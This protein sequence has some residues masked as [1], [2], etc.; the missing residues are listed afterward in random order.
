MSRSVWKAAPWKTTALLLIAACSTGQSPPADP[1]APPPWPFRQPL[2]PEILQTRSDLERLLL[3]NILPFWH[4]QVIDDEDGGYRLNHDPKGAWKGKANK[5]IVT[6]SRCVWFYSRLMRSPHAKPEYLAAAHHGFRFLKEKMWDAEHGG[7]FWEVDSAGTKATVPVKHLYG[8]SFG[9]YALSE[10]ARVSGDA[11]AL[12]LARALVRLLEEK[13]HDAQHGGYLEWFQRDW[14]PAIAGSTPQV[15]GIPAPDAKLMNTHLHL[16]EAFTAYVDLA[17][18]PAARDRLLELLAVQTSAVVRK[19]IGACTDKYRRDWTPFTGTVYDVVSYGHDVENVWL[20]LDAARAAGVATGPY[21]DLC[22]TL[23]DYSLR[24]GWDAE[25]GGFFD[26]GPF[27]APATRRD[28]VWWVQAEGLVGAL[29][30][31]QWTGEKT[32]QDCYLKTLQ[33]IGS[34]QADGEGGDWHEVIRPDGSI[35]GRKAHAWK[36]P[37]HNGRAVLQCL[38]IL[39]S[40]E[41]K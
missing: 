17:R 10:Y 11:E 31:A 21:R 33:W 37:Y 3:K 1:A 38:D 8:Q 41:R 4:P 14:S 24:H 29:A 27:N 39:S 7:F 19:T 34:R 13:A 28:K 12:A 2:Q 40:A 18:E 9:L 15:M 35:G 20:I 26:A 25:A 6:Q 16:M 22:R 23:L 30:M 32:Y 5:A 36:G